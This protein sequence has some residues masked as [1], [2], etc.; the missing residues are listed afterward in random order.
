V[1]LEAEMAHLT[2]YECETR[3]SH[4]RLDNTA[5]AN[6]H[7]QPAAPAACIQCFGPKAWHW[8]VAARVSH[9]VQVARRPD[10]ARA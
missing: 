8:N 3:A 1:F 7:T 4:F 9:E 2:S 10:H 5:A 6:A